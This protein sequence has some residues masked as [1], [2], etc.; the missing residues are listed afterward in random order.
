MYDKVVNAIVDFPEHKDR[1][2]CKVAGVLDFGWKI[3]VGIKNLK[4]KQ[5][6][7]NRKKKN[8]KK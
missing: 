8:T 6:E 1:A 5:I 7:K 3:D 2:L 4:L